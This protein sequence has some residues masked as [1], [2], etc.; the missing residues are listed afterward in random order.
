[1]VDYSWGDQVAQTVHQGSLM[2]VVD[3]SI[4]DL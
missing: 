2:T 3:D 1:M 4:A